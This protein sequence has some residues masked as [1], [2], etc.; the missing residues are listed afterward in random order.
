MEHKNDRNKD[1]CLFCQQLK[2]FTLGHAK[3]ILW[4]FFWEKLNIKIKLFSSILAISNEITDQNEL[5]VIE[6]FM[7]Y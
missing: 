7:I 5:N 6:T 1:K 4:F 2:A 3:L